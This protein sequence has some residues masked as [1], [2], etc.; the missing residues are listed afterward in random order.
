MMFFLTQRSI[1]SAKIQYLDSS[2][3]HILRREGGYYAA[4]A[5]FLAE[6]I[7]AKFVAKDGLK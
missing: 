5:I 3:N 2:K 1:F 6:K 4:M 7:S